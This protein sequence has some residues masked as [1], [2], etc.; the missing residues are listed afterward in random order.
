MHKSTKKQTLYYTN[1]RH[2]HKGCAF[3]IAPIEMTKNFLYN[4]NAKQSFDFLN[5]GEP[6][7]NKSRE[8]LWRA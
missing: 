4:K 6:N 3:L 8:N 7:E 1:K 5:T 2:N